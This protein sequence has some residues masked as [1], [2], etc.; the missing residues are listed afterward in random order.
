MDDTPTVGLIEAAGY[1][2]IWPATHG[3]AIPGSP[4]RFYLEDQ[5]PA[6]PFFGRSR[7]F[8]RI[9]LFFSKGME[10]VSSDR[11]VVPAPA[12]PR[13]WRRPSRPTTPA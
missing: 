6:P 3:A 9:D 11:V 10:V 7:P 12:G 13:P 2:E 5:F 1:T 4:G 8:E